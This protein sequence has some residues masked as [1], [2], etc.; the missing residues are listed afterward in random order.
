LKFQTFHNIV[1]FNCQ[2]SVPARPMTKKPWFYL[3]DPGMN[4]EL[5]ALFVVLHILM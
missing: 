2:Y 4:R 5:F 1:F 3:Q